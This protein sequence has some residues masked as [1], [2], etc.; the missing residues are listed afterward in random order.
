MTIDLGL[1]PDQELAYRATM[2]LSGLNP[3]PHPAEE[4]F[5]DG[6]ADM[7]KPETFLWISVRQPDGGAHVH[8]RWTEGGRELGDRIDN[9]ALA[10]GLDAADNCYITGL[11]LEDRQMGNTHIQ[12]HSL[13]PILADVEAGVRAP[14]DVQASLRRVIQ[15]AAEETGQYVIA[16]NPVV[17]R[18]LGVGPRLLTRS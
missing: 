10:A 6:L 13:R 5:A 2:L 18:W 8:Y 15:L 3:D 16:A 1:T 11:H 14:E 12:V 9:Q 17:P 4:T 7:F